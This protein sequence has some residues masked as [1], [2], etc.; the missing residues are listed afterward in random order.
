MYSQFNF[1]FYI[2]KQNRINLPKLKKVRKAT[3]IGSIDTPLRDFKVYLYK[4]VG[5]KLKKKENYEDINDWCNWKVC[6]V[7]NSCT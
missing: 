2:C 7:C 6:K 1:F 3:K 5:N 4:Y